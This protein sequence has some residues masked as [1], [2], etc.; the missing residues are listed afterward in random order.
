MAAGKLVGTMFVELSLDATKYTKA[1]QEIL[2]GAEKN[3]ANI[4]QA[5]KRVGTTSDKMYEAMRQNILNHLEAIKRSHLT[6]AEEKV[7]A[8][9]S[10][11]AKIQKI[12]EQQHGKQTS[13]LDSMKQNWIA[14]SVA[15]AAAWATVNKAMDWVRLG[16]SAQQ[17]EESF[18]MVAET[19]GE[20]ATE[21]IAGMKRAANGT[22]EE[23]AIMQM[24]VKGMVLDIKGNQLV[25]LMEAARVAARMKGV[26][27]QEAY[28]GITNAIAVKLPKSLRQYGLVT[29]EEMVLV[30]KAMKE[31]VE[32]VD[33]YTLAMI[34]AHLHAAKFGQEMAGNTAE[35]VQKFD[36]VVKE[37]KETMGKTFIAILESVAALWMT[38]G[39]GATAAA[40]GF[41][42][43]IGRTQDYD[44]LIKQS[45]EMMATASR[46]MGV[47]GDAAKA[48]GDSQVGA[49]Q[50]TVEQLQQEKKEWVA[51][52]NAQIK[53]AQDAKALEKEKES[54]NK[55]IVEDT[56]KTNA[57][58]AGIGKS[59][60]EKAQA[61][62]ASQAAEWRKRGAEEVNVRKWVAAETLKATLSQDEEI[63]KA[64]EQVA[65]AVQKIRDK[66]QK[67]S[68]DAIIFNAKEELRIAKETEKGQEDFNKRYKEALGFRTNL[69]DKAME[70]IILKEEEAIAKNYEDWEAG[71]ITL[72]QLDAAN[73]AERAKTG[74]ATDIQLTKK[75]ET[76]VQFYATALG[77]E[78]KYREKK[79]A[80]IEKERLANI[81]AG[82][83]SADAAKKAAQE[84]GD[85]DQALFVAK[86]SQLNAA[87][88]NM[89]QAFTDIGSMF[90]KTSREY[91]VMQEAAKA[92][93]IAQKMVAVANAVAA[94]ANQGLGDPYTAIPRI[95]AM[96]AT[97]ASLLS[98][99]GA[100]V[101]GGGG[102][103]EVRTSRTALGV[104]STENLSSPKDLMEMLDKTYELQYREL[105]GINSGISA[106]NENITRFV[107]GSFKMEG[108][109]ASGGVLDVQSAGYKI[110]EITAQQLMD[111]ILV[112]MTTYAIAN[113]PMYGEQV[114]EIM[115]RTLSDIYIDIL[116][117]LKE[118]AKFFGTDLGEIGRI[119]FDAAT[120]NLAGMD[121][122][123][124]TAALQDYI[125]DVGGAAAE[126]LFGEIIG[127]YQKLG[128]SLLDT[129]VRLMTE[130]SVVSD[131][132]ER[133]GQHLHG[134]TQEALAF[135]DSLVEIAGGLENLQELAANYN[136]MFFSE[137]ERLAQTFQD[138][139]SG[140]GT[141]N[142]R[143][144]LNLAMPST[145][146]EFRALVES[147]DLTTESGRQAYIM[148]LRLADS[149]DELYS[150]QERLTQ[151]YEDLQD[152]LLSLQGDDGAILARQRDRELAATDT[153]LHSLLN[154][155][156]AQEDYNVAVENATKAQA[157]YDQAV[158]ATITAQ[159]N[160][161]TA[162]D[163]LAAAH[164]AAADAAQAVIDAQANY[165]SAVEDG[166]QR[167]TDAQARYDQAIVDGARRVSDAQAKYSEAVADGA[168]RV[169]DAQAR[170]EAA[171]T[172]G[173]KRVADAQAKYTDA[174][175]AYQDEVAKQALDAQVKALEER[176][177]LESDARKA[178][179]DALETQKAF[180]EDQ[181]RL[182]D[183]QINAQQ[184][185]VN[186]LQSVSATVRAWI[187]GMSTSNLAPVQS[188]DAWEAQYQSLKGAASASGAQEADVSAFLEF[189]KQ[190]LEY[191]RAYGG[192][193]LAIYDQVMSD[194][195]SIGDVADEQLVIAQEQLD[196]TKAAAEDAK[197]NAERIATAV[198]QAQ[199]ADEQANAA[200]QAA[201][202]A[203]NATADD[204]AQRLAD[205]QRAIDEA[206]Q[207][208]LDAQ[209]EADQAVA[210]AAQAIVDAQVESDQNIAEAAQGIIDAQA[211][212]ANAIA[213]AQRGVEDAVKQADESAKNAAEAIQRAIENQTKTEEAVRKAAEEMVLAQKALKDAQEREIATMNNL[214]AAQ[215]QQ[216]SAM[217]NLASAM[218]AL[219]AQGPPIVNV[220]VNTPAASTTPDTSYGYGAQANAAFTYAYSNDQPIQD[221]VASYLGYS[222]S[223]GIPGYT[224]LPA[225]DIAQSYWVPTDQLEYWKS[226]FSQFGY[227][228]QDGGL[229]TSP[230]IGGEA[231]PEWF[232]PTYEPERS[233]F[234]RDAPDSFWENLSQQGGDAGRLN[235]GSSGEMTFH[236]VTVLDGK[237]V[238]E[239]VAKH[240]PRSAELSEA[241]KG[242]AR[243]G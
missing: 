65:E 222:S 119:V 207:G 231:G 81:A 88:Q 47:Q 220:T 50:K 41:S 4:E 189:A 68:L 86:T 111:G 237:V 75:L 1:Q 176:L 158:Q 182:F 34:N 129:L 200:G 150:A 133:T 184:D 226:A 205:L 198:E 177:K 114:N 97:M 53:A 145:R 195:Q 157:D 202:D 58:I 64:E 235:G 11:A 117:V 186:R 95:A 32:D 120:L 90:S 98:S 141:I 63:K 39:A 3:T 71:Y 62:V 191:Q 108:G 61:L 227:F 203:L 106:L 101:S 38:I 138:V 188:R 22:V 181:A 217:A 121:A 149:A 28:E 118:G 44:V 214:V 165:A 201:M 178:E 126:K 162:T 196:T 238:A 30:K 94:I 219:A 80:L 132:L 159:E 77:M 69:H 18:R 72:A 241:I 232:V 14:T 130:Y 216:A 83:S 91:G 116:D 102:T 173:A 135:V 170:Y 134:A 84:I 218:A 24:A 146:E 180:Y 99:I 43:L 20:S 242:V 26:S 223:R 143:T 122:E 92:M 172:D 113:R 236:L 5:F 89:Q 151:Q 100:S 78:E 76:E 125:S 164:Q 8:E 155:I 15:I 243:R 148:L 127:Q 85:L 124:A 240:I 35:S 174:V 136:E 212:A 156:Y 140:F 27:V 215:Q 204:S 137:A 224:Y 175:Q 167:V 12:N 21:I 2:A 228:G 128:E 6:T 59:N 179:I 183:D 13:M 82:I 211:D 93:Y 154:A 185:V 213:D 74:A 19:A 37:A 25:E 9:E 40:A 239:S 153:Q 103:P 51:N 46:L 190:Y 31:G 206:A 23:S 73:A 54:L 147:L 139:V 144:G 33:L 7:R 107:T 233:K 10:A 70:T 210:E 169:A 16:A 225:A 234:L 209:V 56:R 87:A 160:L 48:A 199:I 96:V 161:N 52:A 45:G 221:S 66:M 109:F 67:D 131:V 104:S 60:F 79:L 193:Y 55:K 194:V 187:S 229:M 171:V 197:A 142:D 49:S 192:D 115:R 110:G 17:A 166:V 112:G 230:T 152:R 168:A 42:I 163:R 208:I 36:A 57:E 123:E 105:T 29:M